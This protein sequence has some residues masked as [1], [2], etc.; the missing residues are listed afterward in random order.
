M[1]RNVGY[2]INRRRG[3]M[4]QGMSWGTE[5]TGGSGD[6][7]ECQPVPRAP[8]AP[9]SCQGANTQ[10]AGNQAAL[11]WLLNDLSNQK[12]MFQTFQRWVKSTKSHNVNC[13]CKATDSHLMTLKKKK[14]V[15][16][17]ATKAKS[18]IIADSPGT[19][20]L[21]CD[22]CSCLLNSTSQVLSSG[23]GWRTSP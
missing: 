13:I 6:G 19:K 12:Q 21:F 3:F 2:V 15:L 1:F 23:S 18:F 8:E 20:L 7:R 14:K 17:N 9:Q 4:K 11:P 10:T 5:G 16:L 22:L